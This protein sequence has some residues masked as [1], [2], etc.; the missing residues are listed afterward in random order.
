V[1]SRRVSARVGLWTSAVFTG[2]FRT[3]SGLAISQV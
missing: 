3:E 2:S 1:A